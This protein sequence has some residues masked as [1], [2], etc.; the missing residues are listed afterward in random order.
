MKN[1]IITVF[2]MIVLPLI[3]I[4][5]NKDMTINFVINNETIHYQCSKN[6]TITNDIL[7]EITTLKIDGIYFDSEYTKEYNNE[8]L[9]EDTTIYIKE[10]EQFMINFIINQN[11]FNYEYYDNIIVNDEIVKEITEERIEGIY[12]DE[13]YTLRYKGEQIL[14]DIN[15]YIRLF[16]ELTKDAIYFELDYYIFGINNNTYDLRKIINDAKKAVFEES[17]LSKCV[18]IRDKAFAECDKYI[19]QVNKP[20]GEVSKEN[21]CL[22][23]EYELRN[24]NYN[25]DL[26]AYILNDAKQKI[27]EEDDLTKCVDLKNN[28]IEEIQKYIIN[29]YTHVTIMRL[30]S[31]PQEDL[32][33]Y[34]CLALTYDYVRSMKYYLGKYGDC[35][36]YSTQ[37]Y[38]D[39]NQ[40]VTDEYNFGNGYVAVYDVKTNKVYAIDKAYE[41]G[42]ISLDQVKPVYEMYK[43]FES[44]PDVNQSD[45]NF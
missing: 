18:E 5:C 8:I 7:S 24:V 29:K 40:S 25:I 41:Q 23:I 16:N 38:M 36:F 20:S 31:M 43:Y 4:G 27:V 17:D 6:I 13:L 26:F 19:V 30:A 33:K 21:L 11:N 34:E 2:I 35:Y 44:L 37:S 10:K 39:W 3:L 9:T 1:K 42:I 45:N 14:D 15:L 28:A 32:D 12:Y 22:E